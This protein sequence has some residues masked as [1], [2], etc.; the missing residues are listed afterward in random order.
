MSAKSE[1]DDGQLG[2]VAGE[3]PD[4]VVMRA[5]REFSPIRAF[6]LFSG[7]SDSA[8]LAV[9]CHDH[10]DELAFVDTGTAVP[11]VVEYIRE[12]ARWSGK[13]LRELREYEDDPFQAFR[14]LVLGLGEEDR[15]CS[16]CVGMAVPGCAVCGGTGHAPP[17]GFPGPGQHGRAYNRLKE[18]QL[19]RL[20]RETKRGAPRSAKVLYLTGVRRAESQRRATRAAVTRKRGTV[21]ANPLIDWSNTQ[22]RIYLA[23]SG[24]PRSDVSALLHRSG[25]CNCGAFASAAKE[26]AMLKSLWPLWWARIEGLEVEAE[27]AGI[28]WCRWGGYDREGNRATTVVR[29]VAGELCQSCELR[30]FE[31]AA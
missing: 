11:G 7:G 3:N 9:R 17:L 2:L 29:E 4:D 22:T 8:A 1:R 13:P 28:R 14:D 21:Y 25:E 27:C 5:R 30:L 10:Y 24:A 6:C 12:F 15:P 26:R 18:R 20:L 31:E 16:G 19:E 23:H